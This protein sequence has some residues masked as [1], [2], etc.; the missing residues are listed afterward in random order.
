MTDEPE[1]TALRQQVEAL[2]AENAALRDGGFRGS[3]ADALMAFE[4]DRIPDAMKTPQAI[5]LQRKVATLLWV[6]VPVLIVA[7]IVFGGIS[8]YRDHQQRIE[9]QAAFD[10]FDAAFQKEPAGHAP[11]K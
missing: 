6:V 4:Y 8:A 1:I 3:K 10:Q 7:V 11:A 9:S 2:T 5:S